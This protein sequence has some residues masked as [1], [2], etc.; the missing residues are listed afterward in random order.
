MSRKMTL[1]CSAV[2]GNNGNTSY[3]YPAEIACVEDL[4]KAAEYDHVCAKYADGKNTRGRL[5][6]GYRSKK[7]FIEADCLP[8]DCDNKRSN[9]MLPDLTPEE[10]KTPADVQAAFPNVAFYVV[11][12]RNHM[13]MKDGLPARPKFHIYFAMN[14]STSADAIAKLKQKVQQYFPSFDD[15]ALDAARFLYGVEIP[16]A[17]YFDGEL[18]IDEFM[19]QSSRLPEEIPEGERNGTLS[20]Y[21]GRVFKKYGDT[22]EAAEKV[23]E[24]NEQRC[25][26]PLEYDEV[27]TIID[28]AR[29]FFHN[30]VEKDPEY[31]SPDEYAAQDFAEGGKK[32]AVTSEIVKQILAHMNITVRLNVISGIVEIE[33][34]PQQYSK[35]NAAN[36]LPV[37]LKD[38]ITKHNMTCSKQTLDDCLVLVEDENRF[39][40]IADMLKATTHDGMDRLAEIPKILGIED[41]E[42]ECRYLNKWLHQCIA[43]ALNDETAPYGADGVLVLQCEQGAGK[44]LFCSTIAVNP[45]WFAEGISIDLTNKDSVIQATNCW[46]AELGELDSTLKREQS[47]LKAFLTSKTDTYRQPYARVQTRKPRRTSFCATVNPKEFL[48]DETGSRRFWVIHPQNIDCER[49]TQLSREWLMQLWRQVYDQLYKPNPQG[50]RLTAEERA[51]LQRENEQYSKPLPGETELLDMLEWEFPVSKWK[52]YRTTNIKEA[53]RLSVNVGQ[54]GKVLTKLAANDSRIQMKAPHNCKQYLL[55]PMRSGAYCYQAVEDFTPPLSINGAGASTQ[56][57]A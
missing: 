53:L 56:Q 32:I 10:W 42:R 49:L 3:P 24:A 27:E 17:E 7:T 14:K 45:D 6:K 36:V 44:T 41:N 9:P 25:N 33:G 12:S 46:L 23:H 39:N 5:V 38:Y 47:A 35:E 34:M 2:R 29:R 50:F 16:T 40:P 52:W 1:Y 55:P 26:P 28:S 51:E 54:L 8:M 20:R 13:K 21:A 11:Y 43:M 30:T 37:L 31:L 15:E 19:E 48:N 18:T 57:S 22:D 4:Q